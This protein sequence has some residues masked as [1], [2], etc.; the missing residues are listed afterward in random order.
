MNN[1]IPPT[2]PWD[3]TVPDNPYERTY[4]PSLEPIAPPPPPLPKVHQWTS[5]A[6]LIM[7]TLGILGLSGI[8]LLGY[9]TISYAIPQIASFEP[10]SNHTPNNQHGPVATAT[11]T[12]EP[13]PRVTPITSAPTGTPIPTQNLPTPTPT[14]FPTTAPY[15]S[16][17]IYNDIQNAG[18]GQVGSNDYSMTDC[19]GGIEPAG[20]TVD[21]GD[22][23]SNANMS[24]ATLADATTVRCY[25]AYYDSSGAFITLAAV[26]HCVLQEQSTS[27]MIS[28]QEIRKYQAILNQYCV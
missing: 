25:E 23:S 26:H 24:I 4:V 18:L 21:F 8:L 6:M 7:I 5:L 19:N 12:T 14:P 3:T 9:V 16:N 1:N 11:A 28:Q 2:T 13:T 20:G 27:S 10:I 15:S 17:Q 22:V